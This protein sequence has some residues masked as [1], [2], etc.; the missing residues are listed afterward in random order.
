MER[1]RAKSDVNVQNVT[2]WLFDKDEL[3]SKHAI[4]KIL[5]ADPVFEKSQNYFAGR[6]E[7]FKAAL[8]RAKRLRQLAA[9]HEWSLEEHN[10]AVDLIA[11]VIPYGLHGTMFLVPFSPCP[12]AFSARSPRF[13]TNS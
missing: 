5:Q 13:A 4:L 1:E 12:R 10:I 2:E 3:R 8:A 6:T 7:R 11:E 9:E